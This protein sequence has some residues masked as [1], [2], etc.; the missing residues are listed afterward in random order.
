LTPL[1]RDFTSYESLFFEDNAQNQGPR[2]NIW[3]AVYPNMNI[4]N[5]SIADMNQYCLTCMK[6]ADLNQYCL[7]CS[8]MLCTDCIKNHLSQNCH[9]CSLRTMKLTCTEVFQNLS[10]RIR[11]ELEKHQKERQNVEETDVKLK[12]W[13][14][15]AKASLHELKQVFVDHLDKAFQDCEDAISKQASS[16]EIMKEVYEGRMLK[17]QMLLDGIQADFNAPQNL[18]KTYLDSASYT[19]K[20]DAFLQQKPVL[21]ILPDLDEDFPLPSPNVI[22]KVL[23][24]ATNFSYCAGLVKHEPCSPVSDNGSFFREF[25]PMKRKLNYDVNFG[26]FGVEDGQFSEPAGICVTTDGL[27]AV[28]DT[29]NH[30]VQVFDEIGCLKLAFG[31]SGSNPGQMLYPNCI[32]SCPVTGNFVITERTPVHQVQVNSSSGRFI[33]RFGQNLIQ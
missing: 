6:F 8:E 21:P 3:D 30:R 15:R 18:A 17:G 2:K 33:R 16:V 13:M 20:V 26:S 27:I 31:V 29:K 22:A 11:L 23:A 4:P 28:T 9:T 19:H 25:S 14:E 5:M 24:Q 32:A 7:T 12:E 10:T 1:K